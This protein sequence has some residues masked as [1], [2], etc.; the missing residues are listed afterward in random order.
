[1]TSLPNKVWSLDDLIGERAP[2]LIKVDTDGYDNKVLRGASRRLS[3]S[4]PHLFFEYS[5]WHTRIYGKEEPLGIFPYLREIGYR[6]LVIYDN[7]GCP[8]C[9]LD[10]DSD[11]LPMIMNY[12][13]IRRGAWADLL[14]SKD[15]N[16]LVR[17]YESDLKRYPPR[18]D[19]H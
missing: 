18:R 19:F 13:N 8:L 14:V 3:A 12:L 5:P 11:T 15:K 10:I 4:H 7:A 1:M 17:F 9:L 2:D 6:V 16:T